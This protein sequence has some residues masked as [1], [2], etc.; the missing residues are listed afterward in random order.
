M[1]TVQS[2]YGIQ[3]QP[4]QVGQLAQ[5]DNKIQAQDVYLAG[6][7]IKPGQ[8]VY[9]ET[10]DSSPNLG[11]WVLPTSDL[12]ASKV[13]H[14]VAYDLVSPSAVSDNMREIVFAAGSRV[15][16]WYVGSVYVNVG[17]DVKAGQTVIYDKA[18]EKWKP[19]GSHIVALNDA[20]NNGNLLAVRVGTFATSKATVV[21]GEH[22]WTGGS[23]TNTITLTDTV[24]V[25]AGAHV[26]ASYSKK[27][28][29]DSTILEVKVSAE[30]TVTV[31]LSAANAS[32]D[33]V[34]SYVIVLS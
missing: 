22:Q 20:V 27:P 30:N 31:E 6:V 23:A 1:Q 8:G 15:P 11:R 17:T 3:F 16:A 4:G 13:T 14:I 29:E 26:V 24:N 21:S 33:A 34:I 2:Q 12:D 19:G 28:T 32:N 10:N 18:S 25:P 7:E 9:L 5:T